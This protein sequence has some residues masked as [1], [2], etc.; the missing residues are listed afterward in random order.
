[1]TALHVEPGKIGLNLLYIVPGKV[2]G[3]EIYAHELVRAL[4]REAP[5]TAF[6][7]FCGS[8][9]KRSLHGAG[10]P[11]NVRIVA[12]RLPSA[13]KPLRI[14]VEL[15]WL[16]WLALREQVELLHS[17]GTTAPLW[18]H[19]VRIVTVHDLIY[20]H[21]PGTFP[22]LARAGLEFIVP[23]AARRSRRVHADSLATRNDLI[24]TYALPAQ[25]IDV[26]HLGLGMSAPEKVT[27]E[28]ELRTRLGLGQAKIVLSVAAALVHKNLH[29][30]L[31][32]FAALLLRGDP[33]LPA[34]ILVLVGRAGL[35]HA[36]LIARA[37]AL[38]IE[39]AVRFT[40][41][42]DAS[43]LEGLYRMACC[44]VYPSLFEGFGMPVLEAMQRGTPVA[45]S[46]ASSLAEVAG[47]G[48][49]LFDPLNVGAISSAMERLLGDEPHRQKLILRG[50]AQAA[51]FN[52][53][54]TARETLASY[55]RVIREGA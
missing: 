18:S 20:H 1:M 27:H 29:R 13:L 4:A 52:W 41:W 45:S 32:A 16:P 25:R 5:R 53:Q 3:T 38:G 34:P 2:G 46:N 37:R 22:R 9:A 50:R 23:R 14:L 28:A 55:E 44:F 48:A 39:S 15:F 42:I 40:D 33:G 12:V 21:F 35:E 8:E 7:V 10:W 47:E 17:L 36:S 6:V 11:T 30:L 26:I 43:D 54:K 31:D 19:C 24:A 51:K 49:E